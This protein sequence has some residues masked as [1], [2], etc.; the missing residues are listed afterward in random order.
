MSI[1]GQKGDVA[2]LEGEGIVTVLERYVDVPS[3]ANDPEVLLD[4]RMHSA[5]ASR[6]TAKGFPEST[7]LRAARPLMSRSVARQVLALLADTGAPVQ[8]LLPRVRYR[9]GD[10]LHR[11]REPISMA[12]FLRGLISRAE[13]RGRAPHR[14]PARE[15]ML[16]MQL[17]RALGEELDLV[18]GTDTKKT[19]YAQ[20]LQRI[21]TRLNPHPKAERVEAY[22]HR[23][24]GKDA[25]QISRMLTN[26]QKQTLRP[27]LTGKDRASITAQ[28]MALL[29]I[30]DERGG[31]HG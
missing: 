31:M 21:V 23:H 5:G 19:P 11:R 29:R 4:L 22:T 3:Y 26:L 18:L 24:A 17:T 14:I 20:R 1:L 25:D 16:R 28:Q 27:A 13:G 7:F 9:L 2:V 6:G 30:L 8:V 10:A 15:Q 12:K